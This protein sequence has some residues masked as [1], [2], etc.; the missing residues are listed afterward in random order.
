M[1]FLVVLVL[2]AAFLGYI[3]LK[4]HF[5]V[6][7]RLAIPGP[8]P[9][10]ISGN[11]MYILRKGH[12][13]AMVTWGK[14]YGRVFGYFEGWSP[15]IAVSDPDILR[16]ILVKDFNNYRSRKPFPLAPRKALG[17]FLE[18]GDQWKRSRTSLTPA[19]SSGKLRHMFATINNSV[20]HLVAN[21]EHKCEKEETYDAYSLFQSLTL[22]VIGRC[23]FG[24][25]T[26][27]QT[28]E[29]DDFLKNIRFLFDGLSK[30]CIQPLVM[31]M[32]FLS[33]FVF[34][35]KNIVFLFGMNPVVW[36]KNQMKDVVKIRKE[37]GYDNV[38]TDL[39]Q[40]MV[41]PNADGK[42]RRKIRPM[43]EREVVA[44]SMTFLL[45]GYETTS[46]VLAFLTHVLATN[47]GVQ[48]RLCEEIDE[49]FK[50]KE[51]TYEKVNNM[52]YFDMVLDEV[53]RLY[54]TASLVVTRKA[55]KT[56]K[57]A[58][59]TFPSG[60]SIQANVWS[61]HRDEEFWENAEEFN[62]ERFSPENKEKIVPYSFLPFGAGPRMCIGQRFAI[63]E[64]KIAISRILQNFTFT[65]TNETEDSLTII[66]R[67][68]VV[69]RDGV[70]L[71][72][73]RRHSI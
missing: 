61:L 14:K 24:L 34:A 48:D 28:D 52:P 19:F 27:A 63:L 31:L 55:D 8:E 71:R 60:M 37:I 12:L 70:N 20:D 57:Y 3:Y 42:S 1:V 23:A 17:L 67:G 32:P 44:Q 18:N 22:D 39:V 69:P 66:A 41:F 51:V 2:A 49:T 38:N 62:A 30:T 16:E 10:I 68:A 5:S 65:K 73:H 53:C 13:Q 36:L 4:W 43:T 35:L 15:V 40:L 46:A 11:L 64:I 29:D 9:S 26:N 56:R 6:F 33:Y 25:Q 50:G 47:D 72:V 58:G 54:P 21:T 59:Y 7:K 45:A